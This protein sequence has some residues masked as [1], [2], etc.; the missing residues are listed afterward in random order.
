MKRQQW[1]GC[2]QCRYQ[3]SETI[4]DIFVLLKGDDDRDYHLQKTHKGLPNWQ[5]SKVDFAKVQIFQRLGEPVFLLFEYWVYAWI[6]N[7]WV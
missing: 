1:K 2:I 4:A 3:A 5:L 7:Y 6:P